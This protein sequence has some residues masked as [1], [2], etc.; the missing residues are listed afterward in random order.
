MDRVRALA[1]TLL[2]ALALLGQ[3][4]ARFGPFIVPD[5]GFR[6]ALLVVAAIVLLTPKRDGRSLGARDAV[7]AAVLAFAFAL[8]AL[9]R[10]N[11]LDPPLA[12]AVAM[13]GERTVIVES[14][15]LA[16]RRDL[17]RLSGRRR[18]VTLRAEAV[19]EVPRDGDYRF[20]V[21]CD[22]G[23]NFAIGDARFREGA[24]LE[25]ERG[26]LP[27]S[28]VYRQLGG[29]ARLRFGWNTPAA[30][31]LLP[32]EF[33][34][35]ARS[36]GSRKPQRWRVHA[37]LVLLTLW[38]WAFATWLGRI[39]PYRVQI[40]Q[41]RWVPL[42][43]AAV[44]ILYGSLLRFDA[45][46]VHS[47]QD[48]HVHLRHW[49]PSYGAFNPATA[50]DD[51]YRADV[52]S[53]LE[54]A[55]TLSLSSFYA[56]SFREPF[57]IALNLPFLKLAG[58]EIGILIQS[59]FFS[60]AALVLFF[61]V[62]YRLHGIWWATGL[63]VPVALHEWL[64]LEAPSGYRMSAYAFFLLAAVAA[65]FLSPIGRRGA[66]GTGVLSGLLCLIR[67][68]ALSVVGPLLALRLWPLPRR[69]RIR[70]GGLVVVL[71]VV[72]VGPFLVSHA[73][74]H[75]DPFYAVSFHTQ[76]WMRAEGLD[77]NEG[78]VSF[79]RYFTEFGRAGALVRG[80]LL[81]LTALPVETF[82]R[83]LHL[84]PFLNAIT[85]GLGALGLLLSMR[86]EYRFL[87]AAYLSHLVPF[88]YIQNFPSG[89]M[90]RFVMPA[91]FFLVLAIPVAARALIRRRT[92]TAPSQG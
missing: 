11:A 18:N 26:E 71:L 15:Q 67:L 38:V 80:T 44:I 76:F 3:Q 24:T 79:S 87:P 22:D 61:F 36:A 59:F 62:A 92:S 60:S 40:F 7:S 50:P 25:L 74:A 8:L 5:I 65:M 42:T 86:T 56:P 14:L 51:P 81:G 82:W 47:G 63:L 17:R 43:A 54:R 66:I 75:G 6:W 33:F 9:V 35:R 4:G 34:L 89:E 2:A 73:N 21:D 57:Y 52:R 64:I 19:L 10:A 77:A 58:G 31:E 29:P 49:V 30:I 90:P 83:G 55:E 72:L 45:L 20:D 27:F 78:P 84:F 41:R 68:S 85:L 39:A 88:A 53:Y 46:L 23:C 69:E 13:D 91:Y 37:T 48:A 32:M 12:L 1:P 16:A 70:Y 28:L